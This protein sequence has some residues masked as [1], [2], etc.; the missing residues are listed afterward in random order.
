MHTSF[1]GIWV[2]IITPLSGGKIDHPA[3]VRLAGY[4]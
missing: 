2:P 3:L 1:E 4:L